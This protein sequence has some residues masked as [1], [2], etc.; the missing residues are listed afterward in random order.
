M[1]FII[2]DIKGRKGCKF[3][4]KST[5]VPSCWSPWMPQRCQLAPQRPSSVQV[6]DLGTAAGGSAA[7]CQA[8]CRHRGA[9]FTPF[10]MTHPGL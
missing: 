1:T 6:A 8:F 5:C 9:L 10:Q 2:S 3:Y 7:S 4:G